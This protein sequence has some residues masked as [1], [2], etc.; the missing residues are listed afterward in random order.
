[1]ETG[2]PFGVLL[3]SSETEIAVLTLCLR[4][5]LSDGTLKTSHFVYTYVQHTK[6]VKSPKK[7]INIDLHKHCHVKEEEEKE[8]MT[9]IVIKDTLPFVKTYSLEVFN[10]LH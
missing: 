6:S 10:S 9:V 2:S 7:T 1:M 3:S 4:K 8:D 5:D